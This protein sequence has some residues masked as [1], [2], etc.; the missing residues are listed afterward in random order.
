MAFN[1]V[2]STRIFANRV[3]P[4]DTKM[5][6]AVVPNGYRVVIKQIEVYQLPGT[7]THFALFIGTAGPLIFREYQAA[8]RQS[9]S[10]ATTLT[11][12]EGEEIR[13]YSHVSIAEVSLHGYLLSG[14]GAPLV[15][16]TLPA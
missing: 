10:R 6:L 15:P 4:V 13:G 5:V 8:P 11:F 7:D 12:H 2:Y 14:A 9:W 1:A 3:Q 16:G